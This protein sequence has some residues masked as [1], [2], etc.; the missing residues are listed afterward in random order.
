MMVTSKANKNEKRNI[1][2]ATRVP[3]DD[4]IA[5]GKQKPATRNFHSTPKP[6]DPHSS[7]PVTKGSTD[8]SSLKRNNTEPKKKP[9]KKKKCDSS[10]AIN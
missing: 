6:Q 4:P 5:N 10:N 3:N 2:R 1:K 7:K 8:S 9:K